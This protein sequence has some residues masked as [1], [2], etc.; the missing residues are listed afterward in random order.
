MQVNRQGICCFYPELRI[1]GCGVTRPQAC[2]C[3]RGAIGLV[4]PA[5]LE[6][7]SMGWRGVPSFLTER[8]SHHG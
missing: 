5:C 7:S 4:A 8:E 3:M 2:R 1:G 6:A